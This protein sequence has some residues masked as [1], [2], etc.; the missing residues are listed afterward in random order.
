[1][2]LSG[3]AQLELANDVMPHALRGACG[4]GRD[5]AVRKMSAQAAELAVFRPEL[6]APFRNAMRF[7]NREE[8]NR[9]AL[10]PV[11]GVLARQPLR[12]K[13]QETISA[14]ARLLD[15]SR[16]L[17]RRNRTVQQRRW[18][19][20]LAELRH[21]IF[22]Q[23]DQGRDDDDGLVRRHCRGQLVA[24]RFSASR[25]H[26]D[27]GVAACQ[28][29]AHDTF[30]QGAERV[31]SP[32]AAQRGQQIRLGIHGK[33]I[34]FLRLTV[35]LG[36]VTNRDLRWHRLQPVGVCPCKALNPTG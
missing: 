9:H 29:A 32:V 3:V 16:L 22:H 19:S 4:E 1:M 36:I 13:I 8:Q 11:D 35:H 21:L 10:Q 30:L 31:V 20:H 17:H 2:Y 33:S 12:G 34:R 28:Q 7:V 6:V 15:H 14:R 18:N 25:G 24:Q 5:R 27:A 26:D 23:R